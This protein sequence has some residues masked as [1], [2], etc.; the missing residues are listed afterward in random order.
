MLDP[1]VRSLRRVRM[2]DLSVMIKDGIKDSFLTLNP[3][4][5]RILQALNAVTAPALDSSCMK[6]F[7]IFISTL[8][9]FK[10]RSLA[11]KNFLL[12]LKTG[13]L[14]FKI[15]D[16]LPISRGT[17]L[18]NKIGQLLFKLNDFLISPFKSSL[19]PSL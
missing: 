8:Q 14:V 15:L 10:S 6:K 9:P 7:R 11:P 19:M 3:R 2:I 1:K 17:G 4:A 5:R 12:F 16:L 18:A 13:N